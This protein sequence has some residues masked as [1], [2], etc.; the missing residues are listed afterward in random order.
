MTIE[1]FKELFQTYLGPEQKHIL[2]VVAIVSPSIMK[3]LVNDDQTGSILERADLYHSL[4]F[5]SHFKYQ[6]AIVEDVSP[7]YPN[8]TG[9]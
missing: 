9:K 2:K 1:A 5:V 8:K 4:P 6:P 7:I 3:Q